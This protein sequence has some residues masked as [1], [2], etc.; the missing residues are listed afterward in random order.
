[1]ENEWESKVQDCREEGSAKKK[2]E[3]IFLWQNMNKWKKKNRKQR[4]A[5]FKGTIS[6]KLEKIKR[7]KTNRRQIEQR[8]NHKR[9][10]E[11]RTDRRRNSRKNQTGNKVQCKTKKGQNKTGNKKEAW[12]RKKRSRINQKEI[13]K[14][15]QKKRKNKMKHQ[16]NTERTRIWRDLRDSDRDGR[17]K[18]REKPWRSQIS[19]ERNR[20]AQ[21]KMNLKE[22]NKNRSGNKGGNTTSS[23]WARPRR[24]N[25]RQEQSRFTDELDLQNEKNS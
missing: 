12:N 9:T 22:A 5:G 3:I 2:E 25:N 7:W 20:A 16:Q 11:G 10:K 17:T 4:R 23:L 15:S 6:N 1:M 13:S 8:R 18:Q 21:I 24:E 14:R 19:W